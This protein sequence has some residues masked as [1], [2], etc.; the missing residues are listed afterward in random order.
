MFDAFAVAETAKLFI[1][2]KVGDGLE[3]MTIAIVG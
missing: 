1:A 2:D 3:F